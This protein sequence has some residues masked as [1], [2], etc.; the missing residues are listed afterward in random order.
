LSV[1]GTLT[2]SGSGKL[3]TA[4]S[5]TARIELDTTYLAGYSD[6]TT[7]QFYIQASD[8]KAYAGGGAVILDTNGIVVAE[9][10]GTAN[11]LNIGS[12][13]SPRWRGMKIYTARAGDAATAYIQ[14]YSWGSGSAKGQIRLEIFDA[15]GIGI[16][17]LHFSDPYLRLDEAD[18]FV[19]GGFNIRTQATSYGSSYKI[20]TDGS[21]YVNDYVVALGGVHVGGTGDPGT[22]N[23]YVDGDTRVGGGIYVG[24]TGVNPA[25]GCVQ[26]S[27]AG[28]F[29]SQK[30][31]YAGF[32]L[33]SPLSLAVVATW[34]RH[35]YATQWANVG[36]FTRSDSNRRI[37]VP[38]V[39]TWGI[40]VKI[41][42]G[43]IQV[44]GVTD[45]QRVDHQLRIAGTSV[46]QL[47][48]SLH[49]QASGVTYWSTASATYV[50]VITNT[51]TQYI[52]VWSQWSNTGNPPQI[53]GWGTSTS[54]WTSIYIWKIN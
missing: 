6:A 13:A 40:A 53:G 2:L 31:K 7:K 24:G 41:L 26:L 21:L 10:S 3:I 8:G 48:D 28:Y 25:T 39:G 16:G 11:S 23:L 43:H 18:L 34:Y 14:S 35:T 42:T 4:A 20:Q 52:E 22:D 33:S 47:A 49:C 45:T 12:Y 27:S 37:H 36:T 30:A 54:K 44:P 15:S 5:P 19:D 9:G 51:S 17:Y 38:E 29:I 50:A 46:Y 1:T 32:G